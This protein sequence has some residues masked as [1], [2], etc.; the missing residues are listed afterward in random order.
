VSV[1]I[2]FQGLELLSACEVVPDIIYI[3][4]DHHYDSV[5]SDVRKCLELYPNAILV[6]DDYGHYHDVERAVIECASAFGK[7]VFVDANHTWTFY[8]LRSSTGQLF[9]PRPRIRDE[10]KSVSKFQSLLSQFDASS[11][12]KKKRGRN[13]STGL[14]QKKT[15]LEVQRVESDAVGSVKS[16]HSQSEET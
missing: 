9:T 5:L 13:D 1:A 11:K 3:D 4:A 15:K 7:S 8:P 2:I 10:S 6:G 12:R 16:I 14:T